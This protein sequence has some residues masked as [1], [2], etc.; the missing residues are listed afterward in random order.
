M[1]Q[2]E[3]EEHAV[4]SE[5]RLQLT[6]ERVTTSIPLKCTQSKSPHP[7]SSTDTLG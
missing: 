6:E 7:I 1:E 5:K 3:T 2:S 4:E